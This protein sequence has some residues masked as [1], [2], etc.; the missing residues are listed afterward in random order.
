MYIAPISCTTRWNCLSKFSMLLCSCCCLVTYFYDKA[1]YKLYRSSCHL[2]TSSNSTWPCSR[3]EWRSWRLWWAT[4][5]ATSATSATR[6]V[7]RPAS[8][9]S[10]STRS[11]SRH[12][13]PGRWTTSSSW[14][15]AT[16]GT[17]MKAQHSITTCLPSHL[18]LLFR[19][20]MPPNNK[21][22]LRQLI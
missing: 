18:S 12:S 9:T 21:N 14:S 13:S 16:P 8:A 7:R 1:H 4:V 15:T 5:V 20:T 2:K 10:K 19:S 22:F 11:S 6:W 3:S 17:K